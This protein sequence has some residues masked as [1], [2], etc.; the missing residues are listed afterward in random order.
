MFLIQFV[1]NGEHL[2]IPRSPAIQLIAPDEEDRHAAG[3][4]CEEYANI[5]ADWA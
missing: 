1:G 2:V 5:S 3:I 4:E